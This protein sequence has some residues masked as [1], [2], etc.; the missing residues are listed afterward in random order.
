MCPICK[1]PH[2][3][4]NFEY[5]AANGTSAFYGGWKC[6]KTGE[7]EAHYDFAELDKLTP[8]ETVSGVA[9]CS[10]RVWGVPNVIRKGLY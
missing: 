7:Y 8:P 6:W 2:D 9:P 1:V 4:Y 5:K 10:D 3:G